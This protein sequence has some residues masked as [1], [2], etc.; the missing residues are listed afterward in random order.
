MPFLLTSS[1]HL[2]DFPL[3]RGLLPS[4]R[5]WVLRAGHG[6]V[7]LVPLGGLKMLFENKIATEKV[8][9]VANIFDNM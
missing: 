5:G 7:G 3:F 9:L 6:L 4:C 2:C 8:I 1:L